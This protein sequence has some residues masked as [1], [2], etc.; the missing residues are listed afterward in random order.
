MPASRMGHPHN[1]ST[2]SHWSLYEAESREEV[3]KRMEPRDTVRITAT[4][5]LRFIEC[6]LCT[7]CLLLVLS[8]Y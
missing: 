8:I 2:K 7:R 1:I 6:L 5:I 3:E 4:A